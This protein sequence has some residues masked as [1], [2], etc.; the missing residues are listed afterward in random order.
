MDQIYDVKQH[1]TNIRLIKRLTE[2]FPNHRWTLRPLDQDRNLLLCD[3]EPLKG[4]FPPI[5]FSNEP[6]IVIDANTNIAPHAV[7]DA[8]TDIEEF[9]MNGFIDTV[10]WMLEH[11]ND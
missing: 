7:I 5:G 6:P 11:G 10:G 8:H 9:V 4:N 1:A 3:G 2:K